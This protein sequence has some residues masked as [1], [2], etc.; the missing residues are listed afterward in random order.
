MD[1]SEFTWL[2]T[3]LAAVEVF[4]TRLRLGKKSEFTSG[5]T[6]VSTTLLTMHTSC[7]VIALAL[8]IP[9]VATNHETLALGGLAAWWLVTIAGLLLLTRWLP[10]HGRHSVGKVT[11]E[12]SEGPGLSLLAHL[13]MLCGALYFTFV[14]MTERL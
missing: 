10:S 12:W 8:W 14:V 1:W 13:G 2:L 6:A 7:G 9:G 11:D 4:L 3:A 5:R